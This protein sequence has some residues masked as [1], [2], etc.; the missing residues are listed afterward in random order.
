MKVLLLIGLLSLT[1]C[2]SMVGAAIGG[3]KGSED[4]AQYE[5][6]WKDQGSKPVTYKYTGNASLN[7]LRRDRE[8]CSDVAWHKPYAVYAKCMADKGY[9][10]Q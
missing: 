5:Q 10:K 8:E 7:N 9:I 4:A 3:Y 6:D 2:A 1:S